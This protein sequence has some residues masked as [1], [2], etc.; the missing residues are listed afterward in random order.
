MAGWGISIVEARVG[1]CLLDM[2][3]LPGMGGEKSADH[4]RGVSEE[5]LQFWID[6]A[7]VI[8]VHDIHG[9][10]RDEGCTLPVDDLHRRVIL[11]IVAIGS[12]VRRCCA[13]IHRADEAL[14]LRNSQP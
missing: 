11:I 4:E 8:I 12:S 10:R 7:E 2:T 3:A 9:R 5:G 13:L 1:D 14:E 6:G